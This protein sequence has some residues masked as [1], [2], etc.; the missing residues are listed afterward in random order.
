MER[1]LRAEQYVMAL[2]TKCN[3][4]IILLC[5]K[6]VCGLIIFLLQRL[7]K[8]LKSRM[9]SRKGNVI[10]SGG[11]YLSSMRFRLSCKNC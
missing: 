7:F 4:K 6:D 11:F 5:S 9:S 8:L 3:L 2:A 10:R 1:F